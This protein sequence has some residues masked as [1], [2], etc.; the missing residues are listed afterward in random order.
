MPKKHIAIIGA[1]PGGLTAGMILAKRG[2]K[3]SIFEK[4]AKV[5]GRNASITM[6]GY[7]FDIGPTFL[8]MTFILREM[9]TAAG[10][11]LDDYCK[12]VPLDPMYKLS[13]S[14]FSIDPTTNREKMKEQI[15]KHFP[16]NEAGVDRFHSREKIRYDKMYPCLKKDYSTFKEMVSAPLLRALPHLSLGKS[17]MDV[18][19]D[20]FTPEQLRICFTFQAK[21]IGM[22]PWECPAAFAIMPY[23]EHYMGID[24]VMGGLSKIS[25]AMAKV[26]GELGGEI[27]LNTPVKKVRVA[28]KK[29]NGVELA[30][31][32]VV[33]ADVVVINAD[34]GH[35][36]E[37]LFDN[38]V[39]RKWAPEKLRRKKYSCSTFMLYW[40]VD[41]IYDEPHHH[42]VFANDYKENVA[43]IVKRSRVSEDMSVYVRNA[44]KLDPTLAPKG[45]SALYVLVPT[46][47]MRDGHSWG[48]KETKAYRDK[49][50]KRIMDRTGMKDLDKHITCEK[51]IAPGE[52][53]NSRN[54]FLGATFNLGH[55]ISQMLYLRPR[56]KFEEVG[57]C[58]L[59]GGGTHPGSGLPTIYESARISADLIDRYE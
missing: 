36:M 41:K 5:G 29:A 21:Y 7:T 46:P 13:F 6:N 22:S 16:G 26:V 30:G 2:Y 42:I 47:N 33:D 51:I 28:G 1:G 49:V 3:V 35:A 31:G 38:G 4:E 32:G 20:Y 24:H 12:I 15:A 45:H 52:W 19:G 44:S 34:F 8:M 17:L 57:H 37:T 56:N 58:Y 59:V 43:D 50:I 9:F 25:E 48:E 23:I 11:N 40:G 39:I 55:T 18:L 27:H 53:Q 54:L 14:N 10:R